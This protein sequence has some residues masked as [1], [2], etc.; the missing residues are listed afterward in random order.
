MDR[1]KEKEKEAERERGLNR[2][3]EREIEA[4]TVLGVRSE[5]TLVDVEDGD[6]EEHPLP[7]TLRHAPV[8]QMQQQST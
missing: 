4:L 8:Q 5:G 6:F 2:D 3:S 1:S 7:R